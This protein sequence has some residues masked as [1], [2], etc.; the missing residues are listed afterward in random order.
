MIS[1]SELTLYRFSLS[2]FSAQ[3]EIAEALFLS[4]KAPLISFG[5]IFIPSHALDTCIPTP[6]LP[7]Q[8]SIFSVF[9]RQS[10]EQEQ[11]C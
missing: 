4:G 5:F 9:F 10:K 1:K 8:F 3:A 11:L 2:G 6:L 7:S